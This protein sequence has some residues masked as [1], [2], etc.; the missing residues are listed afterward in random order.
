[1]VRLLCGWLAPVTMIALAAPAPAD[2]ST[3][4]IIDKAIKAHGGAK[5]VA[6]Q[7]A[8]RTKS[9]GRLELAGGLDF[10][11]ESAVQLDGKFK[12]VVQLEANGQQITVTTVYNGKKVWLNVN[13][14]NQDVNDKTVE[15]IKEA[16]AIARLA[17][18]T[19]LKGKEY[20]LNPLG[21]I[22]VDGKAAV[23]VKVSTKGHRDVNLYFDKKSGLLLKTERRA[24]D[25]MSRQDVTEERL[26]TEYQTVDGRK[27][28][29][30]V[31]VRRDGKKYL[32]V[33]VTEF[34]VVDD[35]DD[36]EF[37]EP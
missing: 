29:K 20:K 23:G 9:K 24:H 19:V 33:E 32:E 27:V 36:S 11:Q 21:E 13:G 16:A 3:R 37:G 12:E 5:K 17:R 30:K 28:A 31:L 15:E 14:Q 6:E 7:K 8:I 34:K 22:K 18:L 25:P 26:I 10:T 4:A 2:D 35:I 1:M